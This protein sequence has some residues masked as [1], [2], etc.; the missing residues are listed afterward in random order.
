MKVVR[1]L[2]NKRFE[3]TPGDAVTVRT[4]RLIEANRRED[5]LKMEGVLPLE[6]L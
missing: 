5:G 2:E 6:P 3:L 4:V 1:C